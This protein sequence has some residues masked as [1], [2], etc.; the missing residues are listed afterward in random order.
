MSKEIWT[1]KRVLDWATEYFKKNKIES[2][3]LESEIL[4]SHSLNLK[5]IDLYIKFETIMTDAE[6]AKFKSYVV[7]RINHEPSAYIT[8]KKAFMSLDFHVTNDVL[9]PRPETEMLV[10]EAIAIS[11]VYDEGLSILDIGTGSGA[12]AVSLAKYIPNAKIYATDIS[13]KAIQIATK[14]MTD[15]GFAQQITV[16]KADLFPTQTSKFDMIVSNP[17]YIKTGIINTLEPEVRSFEPLSAIDG[18]EDGLKYYKVIAARAK[19]YLKDNGHLMLEIDPGLLEAISSLLTAA[20]FSNIRS[21]N[22]LNDMKRVIIA[23]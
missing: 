19:E 5:R 14:N 20:G 12:I 16:E 21:K 6:L 2:P 1:I 22:D 7:R 18:G 9:I 8:G 11:K 13:E 4:L 10:E 23:S 3:R 17:P 15:L